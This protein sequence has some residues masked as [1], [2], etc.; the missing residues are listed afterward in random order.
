[1]GA[2]RRGD[3]RGGGLVPH[4]VTEGRELR[5]FKLNRRETIPRTVELALR[6]LEALPAG[7]AT[8]QR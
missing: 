1:M 6:Y 7:G 5:Q 3:Y 8:A 2:V 4:G